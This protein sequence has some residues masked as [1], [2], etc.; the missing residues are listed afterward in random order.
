[1]SMDVPALPE[2]LVP[3]RDVFE[4]L[5]RPCVSHRA[6]GAPGALG[7][8]RFFGRPDLPAGM[9]WPTN[10]GGRPLPFAF[11]INLDEVTA[12]FP[13]RVP[14]PERPGLLQFFSTFVSPDDADV[15]EWDSGVF[16]PDGAFNRILVHRDLTDLRPASPPTPEPETVDH[17]ETPLV[18]AASLSV[19]D[20]AELWLNRSPTHGRAEAL[21]QEDDAIADAYTEW[22]DEFIEFCRTGGYPNWLQGDGYTDAVARERGIRHGDLFAMGKLRPESADLFA[23]LNAEARHWHLLFEVE[24]FLGEDGAIYL[25]APLDA[26]GRY[27]LDRVQLVYQCT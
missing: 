27:D 16:R 5:V 11:Q 21:L 25:V 14:L 19:P 13:G 17:E 10:D 2:A 3:H 22:S 7:G 6:E 15:N 20:R 1:M 26:A 23:D 24:S 18:P 8:S 12:A 4:A 9:P